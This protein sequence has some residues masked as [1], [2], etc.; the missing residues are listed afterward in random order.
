[1]HNICHLICMVHLLVL[2]GF[3]VLNEV[4]GPPKWGPFCGVIS[5]N[6]MLEI[7][8]PSLFALFLFMLRFATPPPPHPTPF[9]FPPFFFGLLWP[10]S[11][12]LSFPAPREVK[13]AASSSCCHLSLAR[14]FPCAVESNLFV[15]SSSI[16]P[17]ALSLRIALASFTRKAFSLSLSLSLS[18][19]SSVSVFS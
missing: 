9:F 6:K 5:P 14:S 19:S 18:L 15:A 17:V 11:L 10:F 2:L 12:F 4:K 8:H 3:L 7:S 13:S 1:M 16:D